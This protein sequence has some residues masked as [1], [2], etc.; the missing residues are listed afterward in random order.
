MEEKLAEIVCD[1]L[2][3]API[4]YPPVVEKMWSEIESGKKAVLGGRYF[5]I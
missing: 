3:A 4:S 1:E 2:T 5:K